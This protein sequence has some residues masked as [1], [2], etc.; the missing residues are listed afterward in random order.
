MRVLAAWT[1][2]AAVGCVG[3]PAALECQGSFAESYVLVLSPGEGESRFCF[4]EEVMTDFHV[5]P[6][7]PEG[8]E[9]SA[10]FQAECTRAIIDVTCT[11][12]DSQRLDVTRAADGRIEGTYA[13]LDEAGEVGCVH[14]I[15]GEP[16]TE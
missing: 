12:S 8:C 9:I 2:V 5:P 11:T 7:L 10:S 1:V 15:R 3:S 16:S 6:A 14:E 13:R 4:E